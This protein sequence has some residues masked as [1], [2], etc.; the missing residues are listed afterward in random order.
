MEDLSKFDEIED[1]I[2]WYPCNLSNITEEEVFLKRS[3]NLYVHIPFCKGGC[4]FCPF[5]KIFY[6]ESLV[7]EYVESLGKEIELISKKINLKELNIRTIWI[8]GGTP[9]DLNEKQID[10]VFKLLETNFNYSNIEITFEGIADKNSWNLKKINVLKRHS[11]TRI[12]LGVQ[13]LNDKYL[14]IM[15]RRYSSAHA[16]ETID[17][18]NKN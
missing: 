6:N 15:G 10:R 17:L 13:S 3:I 8:G 5:N 12:S 2:R 11:V 9:S 18:L 14:K 16:F 4:L 7:D 1:C